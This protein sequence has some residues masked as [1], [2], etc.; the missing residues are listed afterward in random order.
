MVHD[1]GPG[2][3]FASVHVEMDMKEDP[4]ACHTIID[5]VERYCLE[6]Y[7]IHLVIHYDP[8]VTD[9]VELNEMRRRVELVLAS[10]DEGIGIH[11]FRLVRGATHTN[12][13]F[14]M[15]L[16]PELSGR[17]KQVKRQLD[18]AINLQGDTRYYTVITFDSPGFNTPEL[19][20]A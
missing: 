5:D 4:L 20:K 15:T 16:P 10:I 12:L 11:D 14:D 19:W 6:E 17:E 18:T 3:R 7:R 1:Y 13:I 2:Q 9:D 8:I